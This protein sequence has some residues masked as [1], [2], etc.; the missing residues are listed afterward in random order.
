MTERAD[1]LVELGTEELPPKALSALSIAFADNFA[2]RLTE[3]RLSYQEIERFATPRRL[4]LRVRGLALAQPDEAVEQRGPPVAIALDGQG[5]PTRAAIAFAERA[6]VPVDALE[7]LETEKGAWLLHKATQAGESAANRLPHITAAALD[8]LPIPKRMRWGDSDAEFVRPVHWLVMLLG[9]EIVPAEILGQSAGRVTR[10][11]RVHSQQP[12]TLTNPD[13]YEQK[14]ETEG[15]VI[16]DFDQR[17]ERVGLLTNQAAEQLG[18]LAVYDE[19]LLDE[20]TALVEWPVAVVGRF[21]P[22][23]LELPEEVLVATLQGHQRFFPV[24]DTSGTLMDSFIAMANLES[25]APA[26]VRAGFERVVRPRL[27][28]AAFFFATDRRHTLEQRRGKLH[29]V[30]FQA[31][32]GSV[33][34][35]TERVSLLCGVLADSVGVDKALLQRA[36]ELSR[37]DLVTE[38]V[39]EFPELQGVMGMYYARHDQEPEELA[40]ALADQYRPRYAGDD[41]P[42]SVTG[43]CLAIA[44]K[45]D[46]ITGIFAIGQRPSGTR[47]PYGLRRAALGLVRIAIECELEI[48]LPYLI[49]A[50]AEQLPVSPLPVGLVA[51]VYDYVIERLAGYYREQGSDIMPEIFQAVVD[52]RPISPRDFDL[53]A[54]ALAEFVRHDA[55]QSLAAANKRVANILRKSEDA[56]PERINPELLK[57]PAE[58]RLFETLENLKGSVEALLRERRYSAAMTEL[59]DTRD[60]IDRFFDD[61]MVN[62]DD[63]ELRLNRLGLLHGIR[64][65]YNGVGDISRLHV[66]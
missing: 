17:R 24:R 8:A 20:V 9:D 54:Q 10:G 22:V 4:A 55:A 6:G 46:L 11:H 58:Q 57:E 16:A 34:D 52:H 26:Q 35:V 27:A 40:A 42:G 60:V 28:D 1:F 18:G 61:V 32:L 50:A 65:L 41:L 30:L 48:D 7:R 44:N 66:S 33:F 13:E 2:Q 36:A 56:V 45:I 51:E 37:S 62:V 14:L 12:I 59:A 3:E 63:V 47:D 19:A 39:G 31:K 43:Q 53:R 64:E 49:S 38:M 21:D 25:T 15:H 29:K 23:Y 5:K